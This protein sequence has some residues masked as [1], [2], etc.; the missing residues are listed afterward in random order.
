MQAMTTDSEGQALS[1]QVPGVLGK[2]EATRRELKRSRMWL[3]LA[4]IL[5]GELL[6]GAVFILADWM[7][8]LP[9]FVRGMGLLA[10]VAL[11]VFLHFRM[12]H[13]WN[14]DQAAAEVEAHFTELGQRLRTVVEYAEPRRAPIPASPGLVRALGR[15]TDK[16]TAGLD[17]RK[18]VP[19]APFERRAIGL[20]FATVFGIIV[21]LMNPELR[22]AAIRTL[23]LRPLHYTTIEVEPGDS[24]VKAGDELKLKV[25]LSGRPVKAAHWFYRETKSAS[26]WISASL[27]PDP[28]TDEPAKLLAGTL[29]TSLKDCQADLEYRIVAG[30]AK[31]PVFH[32]RVLKP[33][34]IKGL[35]A[36][37][38]APA[39]T[40]RKPEV[41][42]GGNLQ[43]I[44][45]SAV[46][47]KIALDHA[48]T[49]AELV[50]E[51]PGEA[52]MQVPLRNLGDAKLEGRLPTVTK[53]VQFRINAVDAEGMKLEVDPFRIKVIPDQKPTLSFVRPEDSLAV[54][55]TT[56]VP[57]EVE[58]GDDFGLSQVGITYKVGNG[59]EETLHVAEFKDRLVT[60]KELATLYLEKHQIAYPDQISYYAFVLDNHP[61]EPHK[62][63]SELRFIDVLP[64]KQEYQFV[65]GE[66]GDPQ[67]GSLSLEE[68]IARQRVN[69]SRTFVL[70]GDHTVDEAAAMRL[71]T[72]EEELATA[73]TEFSEGLK[74]RG[75]DLPAL[76][77]AAS[78]MK[79][80]TAALDKK[81]LATAQSHEEAALKSLVSVRQNLRK[82]LALGNAGQMS[83]ARS[84]DR[85][86][87]QKIRRPPQDKKE[88]LEADL[89]ELAKREEEFSEEIEAKGGGGVQLEPPP[90][91]EQQQAESPPPEPG[92][93]TSS[94][95][96][97]DPAS[98]SEKTTSKGKSPGSNPAL[99]QQK[100]AAEAERLLRLAQKDKALTD[101][102]KQ[103]LDDAAKLV[104]EASREM[105]AG[106]SAEA[107]EKAREAARKLESAARQVGALKSKELADRLARERDLAQAIAKAERELGKS[108]EPGPA[109]SKPGE[110]GEGSGKAGRQRELAGE[111]AALADVLERLRSEAALDYRELAQT[112]AQ[113]A[114]R[115]PPRDV[116]DSMRRN[117]EAIASGRNAEAARDADQAA[118]RLEAL[119]QDLE[120]VRR[121]AVQPQ[122]ERLLSAEKQ[123]AQLQ[124]KLRSLQQRSQ[125]AEAEKAMSDLAGAVDK[126]APGEGPLRQA[127]DKLASAITGAHTGVLTR[128]DKVELGQAG[129]F[130]PPVGYNDGLLAVTL[131]LQ[132]KIQEIILDSALAER[133]GPVPPRY[134]ELVE[135]YYRVLS[136]DLR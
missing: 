73:T 48:P 99:D 117:A 125:L 74:G 59:P 79:S 129:Y 101:L 3:G 15:D 96:T 124:E 109:E 35:E 52:A 2:L 18:L 10:M 115:N 82:L 13:Q 111:V 131:A 31:S 80:A 136:Q 121:S 55:P 24:T 20:F 67:S 118:Q 95:E 11:A 87:A 98:S 30:D 76:D 127:A 88:Q 66:S 92:E 6:L 42:Q 85:Q 75:V 68:L 45:G 53:N 94:P 14:S 107:A 122:L 26:N 12:R 72:F 23:F 16:R 132:A 38:I 108:L 41:V 105:D 126:L 47:L 110:K 21:L 90:S 33:L 91:N 17:F 7:W 83:A 5:L 28:G 123:A 70:E 34:V 135:D 40:G 25:T 44:E 100:A 36:S 71:S 39:Y 77:E 112:I 130:K 49:S 9:P 4:T 103:R 56:E 32:V 27:A 114:R 46:E 86:Q 134:K 37:V 97:K 57:I 8:V 19:W 93:P 1:V 58:A 65:E 119:A 106:R 29:T 120:A 62:V 61:P 102:A 89:L 54:T 69:L 63:V 116:E 43:V 60:A 51:V 22:T 81:D 128:A 113:A 104:Q 50:V 78:A 84:F 64:Y 133:D